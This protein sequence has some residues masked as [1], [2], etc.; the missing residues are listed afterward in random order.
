MQGQMQKKAD[1]TPYG[2][3]LP[4]NVKFGSLDPGKCNREAIMIR[5]ISILFVLIALAISG[6]PA[7]AGDV[8][9]APP[10]SPD[11]AARY[12]FYMHGG[13]PERRGG[14]A[15]YKYDSILETLA[16]KGFVVIGEL[17]G[18][19]NP[20]QY[21]AG[22]ADQVQSLLDAGVP[23]ANITVAGHSKGGLMSMVAASALGNPDVKFGVMAACGQE[24]S[25]FNRSYKKFVKR[26]AARIKGRFLVAWAEDDDVAGNCDKAL[27]KAGV[28]YEN[29]VLPAGRGHQL[30]YTPEPVWID[31]LSAYA[32]GN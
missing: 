16:D 6:R 13:Y 8:M 10:A 1:Q 18:Q 7:T 22:I 12:L 29:K 19:T 11:P 14:G 20:R 31:L 26:S 15:D 2:L 9:S 24:G 23:T 4:F 25:R 5:F 3:A 28:P 27:N 32:A 21:G 30:F 17:R